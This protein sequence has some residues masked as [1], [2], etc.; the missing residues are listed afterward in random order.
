MAPVTK[1]QV[2]GP[3]QQQ[4]AVYEEFARSLPGFLPNTSKVHT[5]YILLV[6]TI[7]LLFCHLRKVDILERLRYGDVS[8][9]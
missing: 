4:A 1:L 5:V 6:Q 2:G 8:E 9:F 3:S 7:T